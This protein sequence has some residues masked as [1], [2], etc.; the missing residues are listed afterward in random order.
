MC[1]CKVYLTVNNIAEIYFRL[2]LADMSEIIDEAIS[3]CTDFAANPNLCFLISVA[4]K[5]NTR[6]L[7]LVAKPF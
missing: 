2:L 7:Y 1:S 4:Y 3:Y 5:G 6:S